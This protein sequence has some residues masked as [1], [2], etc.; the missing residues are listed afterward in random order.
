MQ[1]FVS[2]SVSPE[3]LNI[4]ELLSNIIYIYYQPELWVLAF[5]H[6]WDCQKFKLFAH[7]VGDTGLSAL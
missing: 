2:T 5:P 7:V 3:L 6:V 1:N 4:A